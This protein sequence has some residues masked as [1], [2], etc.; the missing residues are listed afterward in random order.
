MS[1]KLLHKLLYYSLLTAISAC[2]KPEEIAPENITRIE[3]S[4]YF[5]FAGWTWN[6]AVTPTEY[7]LTQSNRPGVICRNPVSTA[8]WRDLIQGID[9]KSYLKERSTPVGECCDRGSVSIRV[10]AG[11]VVH[12]VERYGILKDSTAL[13]KLSDRLSKRL[14][15]QTAVCK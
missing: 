3:Y 13:G 5:G 10:T 2:T 4:S 1:P 9:W 12:Q 7:T 6:L 8:D 15:D 11:R 14:A